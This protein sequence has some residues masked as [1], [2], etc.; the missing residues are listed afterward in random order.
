MASLN[1]FKQLSKVTPCCYRMKLLNSQREIKLCARLNA[2]CENNPAF[3]GE[4]GGLNTGYALPTPNVEV[5]YGT[6]AVAPNFIVEIRDTAD[7]VHNKTL[8]WMDAGVKEVSR[9]SEV[10]MTE[11]ANLRSNILHGFVLK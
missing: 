4:Y 8:K 9:G 1:D 5:L 7:K 6:P 2:L 11:Y 3:V 10:T